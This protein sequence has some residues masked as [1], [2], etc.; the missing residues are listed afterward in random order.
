MTEPLK[1]NLK[2]KEPLKLNLKKTED[3]QPVVVA[4][5]MTIPAAGG[6]KI[7]LKNARIHADKV[8]IKKVEKK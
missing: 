1:L 7:I 2:K 8:I 5:S 6:I 3:D 4:P